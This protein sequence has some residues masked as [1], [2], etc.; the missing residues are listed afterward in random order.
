[1][2]RANIYITR[3]IQQEMIDTLRACHDVEVSPHDRALTRDELLQ[4]V[5]G[6]DAVILSLIHISEPTRPY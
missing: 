1:M 6:R 2:P 5:R 4:Q 3:M